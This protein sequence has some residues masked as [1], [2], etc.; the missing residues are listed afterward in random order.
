M[1]NQAIDD[2]IS[3]RDNR[4]YAAFERMRKQIDQR[5]ADG[6]TT[7]AKVKQTHKALD[8]DFE[9]YVKLQE[10]KSLAVAAGKLT[11]E[12]GQSIYTAL[13]GGVSAF[14]R[15]PVHIKAVINSLFA[16]LLQWNIREQRK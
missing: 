8:M 2:L 9:E 12:E 11:V 5:I 4:V 16:E 1:S 6:I 7:K 13:E 15:Q 14:N 10:V 3:G